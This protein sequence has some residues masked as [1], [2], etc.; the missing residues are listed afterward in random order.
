MLSFILTLFFQITTLLHPYHIS[1]CDIVYDA[2]TKA[3][4]VSQRVFLD[5][6][7]D[8]LKDKYGLK[9][10]VM[11][12]DEQEFRDSLIQVYLFGHLDIKVDGKSR[13]RSYIGNEI[14]EDGM[15]CYIEYTGVKKVKSLEV[16]NTVFFDKFDD[17]AN[18]IHFKYEGVTK[19][20]KF[21]RQTPSGTFTPSTWN[22]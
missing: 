8:A 4:Q 11:N 10:D 16:R 1:V 21:D 12:P 9:V 3:L 5:D 19:S 20:L 2:E 15:W 13:K 6:L 17:Q 14:T 22:D 7:E 18:V